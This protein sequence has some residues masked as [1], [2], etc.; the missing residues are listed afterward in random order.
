[1]LLTQGFTSG[2][3]DFDFL[4]AEDQLSNEQKVDLRNAKRQFFQLSQDHH[5]L[6]LLAKSKLGLNDINRQKSFN[7]IWKFYE[8]I[9]ETSKGKL[10]LRLLGEF[11]RLEIVFDFTQTHV[12]DIEPTASNQTVGKSLQGHKA[13]IFIAAGSKDK[14]DIMGVICHESTH[15]ILEMVYENGAMPFRKD[16]MVVRERFEAIVRDLFNYP[17]ELDEIIGRV[18]TNYGETTINDEEPI[19]PA[20]LSEMI[21]RVIQLEIYYKDNQQRLNELKSIPCV[22]ALFDFYEQVVEKDIE[23]K[24]KTIKNKLLVKEVNRLDGLVSEIRKFQ[25]KN[26]RQRSK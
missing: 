25:V 6:H 4:A 2:I 23:A 17:G 1:M 13:C 20:L 26:R 24:L 12:K 16:D 11:D 10:V 15:H 7:T 14:N 19:S 8:K 18:F 21:V 3:D 9:N 5:I 22:K